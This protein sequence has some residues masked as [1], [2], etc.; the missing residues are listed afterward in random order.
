[1]LALSADLPFMHVGAGRSACGNACSAGR[2]GAMMALEINTSRRG[3]V[4]PALIDAGLV[5]LRLVK[6]GGLPI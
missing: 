3:G 5:E 6:A 2:P 1:M 4:V